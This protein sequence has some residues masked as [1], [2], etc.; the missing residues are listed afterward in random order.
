METMTG[1]VKSGFI[2]YYY[3][4]KEIIYKSIKTEE[5]KPGQILSPER[6]LCTKYQVSRITVRKAMDLLVQEGLIYREKGRGTFVAKPPLE[7][8]AQIISFTEQMER[9]GLK[10]STRVLETKIFSWDKEIADCLSLNVDEEIVLVKRLRLA[11]DEPVAL[12]SSYLPHKLYPQVLTEDLTSSL[13]KITEQKY[14][15]C[16]A[17]ATQVVKAEP[18]FGEKAKILKVKAGS[19]VLLV[20]RISFLADNRSAEYLEAYYRGDR[21]EITMELKGR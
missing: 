3:Q 1:V 13:T 18:V 15:L 10:S 19:P 9:K 17:R 5:I 8:P 12:E 16:L 6:E 11:N 14:H 21:Y 2:P 20:K 4:L 7:Q